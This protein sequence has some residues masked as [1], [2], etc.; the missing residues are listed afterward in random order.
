MQLRIYDLDK[1]NESGPKHTRP[2]A[3]VVSDIPESQMSAKNCVSHIATLV[4][5]EFGIDP[6]RVLWIEYYPE[7]TYGVKK[8]M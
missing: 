6:N 3:V 5:K 1:D 7:D 4:S 8:N 2:I